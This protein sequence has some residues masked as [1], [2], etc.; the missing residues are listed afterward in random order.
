MAEQ[1]LHGTDIIT[2]FQ[3]MDGKTVAKGVTVHPFRNPGL[4]RRFFHGLL[5]TIF[6]NVV[7]ACFSAPWING[8]PSAGEHIL[9]SPFLCRFGRF[10]LIGIGIGIGKID[11]AIKKDQGIQRL[12]L[13][14]FGHIP[15]NSQMPQKGD[16]F[17][18]AKPGRVLILAKPNEPR[19]P[20]FIR[21]FRS[22]GIPFCP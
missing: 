13:G 20:Y 9:P 2:A 14:A 1:I 12:I 11:L 4:Q 18:I 8:K 7:T 6:V 15:S 10:A 22:Y 5:K 19:H 3:K 21:L 17:N 16:H